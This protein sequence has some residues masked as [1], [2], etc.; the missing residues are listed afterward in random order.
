MSEPTPNKPEASAAVQ[1][2]P[3][4]AKPAA[5]A[6]PTKPA[7]KKGADRRFFLFTWVGIAWATFTLS[8]LGMVLGTVRFLFPNV[9]SEPPSSF[10][11]GDPN[12]YEE[13]RVV[14][15]YK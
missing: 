2:P 4:P 6:A 14:E 3:M 11:A 10:K 5:P 9:L 15:R 7:A 1:T 8:M 13:G 12:S